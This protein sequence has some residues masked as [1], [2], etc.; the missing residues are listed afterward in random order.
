MEPIKT[1]Y[2]GNDKIEQVIYRPEKGLT[3]LIYSTHV[4]KYYNTTPTYIS[5]E[6]RNQRFVNEL[7]AYQRFEE[8][9]C[10]FVPRLLDFSSS[11]RRFSISRIPGQDLLT[12]S[13]SQL[14]SLPLKSIIEQLDQMN[15]WLRISGFNDLEN[16]IKDM[17]LNESGKLFL[18]DF[19]TYLPDSSSSKYPGMKPDIY[20]GLIDD[21]LQRIFIRRGR[22][23]NLTPRFIR[24]S[25]TIM[26]K[27]PLKTLTI[28][29]R[30]LL[31]GFDISPEK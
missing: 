15:E 13:Q 20:N 10:P 19:E 31:L 22:T 24:L 14:M 2:P 30:Y 29:F 16:N 26:G 3:M 17:I 7:A 25:V 5:L 23:A 21:I 18:V 27:R 12:L 4:V 11:E 6:N 28:A 9:R 1:T 8:L